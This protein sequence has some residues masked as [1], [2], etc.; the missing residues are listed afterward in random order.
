LATSAV[1]LTGGVLSGGVTGLFVAVVAMVLSF[2]T[3]DAWLWW[4]SRPV[5]AALHAREAGAVLP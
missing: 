1:I 5:F 4:R 2:T 3:Q